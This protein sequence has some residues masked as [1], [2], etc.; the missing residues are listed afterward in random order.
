MTEKIFVHVNMLLSLVLGDLVYVLDIKLFTNRMELPVSE[1]CLFSR[2]NI[3]YFVFKIITRLHYPC[4][5]RLIKKS[6]AVL[7]FASNH[8]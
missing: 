3:L 2:T 4:E 7:P 5:L 8:L 1:E 6:S